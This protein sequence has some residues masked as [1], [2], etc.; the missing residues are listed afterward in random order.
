[1]SLH[2]SWVRYKG[3][4]LLLKPEG[5]FDVNVVCQHSAIIILF[6]KIFFIVAIN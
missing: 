5:A 3:D 6:Q 1:M 4:R 2:W